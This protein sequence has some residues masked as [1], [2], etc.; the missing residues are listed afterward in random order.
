MTIRNYCEIILFLCLPLFLVPHPYLCQHHYWLPWFWEWSFAI[1]V[2][3][4][5]IAIG[6][7]WLR[8][9]TL[10][11][12]LLL[13]GSLLLQLRIDSIAIVNEFDSI[14][15]TTLT[16]CS[17]YICL[18]SQWDEPLLRLVFLQKWLV[19]CNCCTVPLRCGWLYYYCYES[20]TIMIDYIMIAA[21]TTAIANN[22]VAT[23]EIPINLLPSSSVT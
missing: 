13:R 14:I 17:L 7:R 6:S 10:W 23:R 15:M 9:I 12:L 11:L 22:F 20:A 1:V 2:S 16:P 21:I 3:Y 4:S 8:L 5:A 19:N 18:T